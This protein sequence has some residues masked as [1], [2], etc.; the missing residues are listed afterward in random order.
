MHRFTPT[1]FLAVFL[2]AEEEFRL[3]KGLLEET[4]HAV[5]IGWKYDLIKKNTLP[6]LIALRML[7]IL[8]GWQKIVSR[9]DEKLLLEMLAEAYEYYCASFT[10]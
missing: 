2:K 9:K 1:Q 6:S 3:T 10:P 8:S 7:V 4:E 5:V